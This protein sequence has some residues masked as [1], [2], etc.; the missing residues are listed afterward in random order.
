MKPNKVVCLSLISIALAAL[1][2]YAMVCLGK[3][4]ILNLILLSI[5]GIDAVFFPWA[6]CYHIELH[7]RGEK[8]FLDRFPC[9][10]GNV[11][12]FFLSPYFAIQY[13]RMSNKK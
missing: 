8:S 5:V 3:E 6:F 4:N 9:H 1:S 2:V 11:L 12:F 13:V 10:S 7:A